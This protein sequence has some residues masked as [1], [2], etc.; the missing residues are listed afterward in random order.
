MLCYLVLH[1][2]EAPKNLKRTIGQIYDIQFEWHMKVLGR[3]HWRYTGKATW[4]R[5]I[6]VKETIASLGV[7]EDQ[8]RVLFKPLN[9][10]V[11]WWFEKFQGVPPWGPHDTVRCESLG[12]LYVWSLLFSSLDSIAPAGVLHYQL[13]YRTEH[14]I[15]SEWSN[16]SSN[17]SHI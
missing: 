10:I 9:S 7:M 13:F 3:I 16:R 11:L 14:Q 8:L 2:N 5:R 4:I 6:A 17:I 15:T 1:W 12:Q